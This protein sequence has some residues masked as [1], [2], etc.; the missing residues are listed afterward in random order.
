MINNKKVLAMIPAR[1]GSKGIK[2]KNILGIQGKPL[3]TYTIEAAQNSVYIDDIV[4]STDSE[5]IK[6]ISEQYNAWVPF[7][8]PAELAMDET[9]TIDAVLYTVH[10]LREMGYQYDILV[11]LQPTS[12]LRTGDDIDGAIKVFAH[13]AYQPLVSVSSVSDHPILIRSIGDNGHLEKL[14]QVENSSVR[15]Q[16]MPLYYRVNGSIYI[17]LICEINQGTSFNDNPIPYIMERN[18]AIDIDHYLDVALVE[19]CLCNMQAEREELN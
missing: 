7:L 6:Q 15:R 1:G 14:L 16:D 8:R 13:N 17:N 19:Y 11:L 2:N 9:P 3:I 12:P 18:H 4:V 5:K 10:K